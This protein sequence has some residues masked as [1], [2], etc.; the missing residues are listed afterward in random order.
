MANNDN[1]LNNKILQQQT[2]ATISPTI[3]TTT[4]SS[5]IFSAPRITP[6]H[7]HSNGVAPELVNQ[8]TGRA[9]ELVNQ[10]T[11]KAPKLVNQLLTKRKLQTK[12]K[13]AGCRVSDLA[14]FPLTPANFGVFTIALLQWQREACP[15]EWFPNHP[16]ISLGRSGKLNCG[17][18]LAN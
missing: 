2:R 7:Q 14:A 10:I 8:I 15:A 12:T 6:Q 16:A 4:S 18:C 3:S 1:S 13:R 17:V 9:P 11:G 5:T